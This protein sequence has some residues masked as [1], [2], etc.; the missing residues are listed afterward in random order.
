MRVCWH[1]DAVAA[2]SFRSNPLAEALYHVSDKSEG[3]GCGRSTGM[4]VGGEI[5][6]GGGSHSCF[7]G[8]TTQQ[9]VGYAPLNNSVI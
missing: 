6:G 3:A 4:E 2:G 9:Q 7:S 8:T 5:G 1:L